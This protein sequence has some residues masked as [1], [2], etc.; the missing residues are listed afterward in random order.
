ML[1]RSKQPKKRIDY[2]KE[3]QRTQSIKKRIEEDFKFNT[4]HNELIGT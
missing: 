2:L 1:A 3:W 4:R